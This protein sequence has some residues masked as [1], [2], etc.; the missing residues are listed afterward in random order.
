MP[1]SAKLPELGR[2]DEDDSVAPVGRLLEGSL[3]ASSPKRAS[4]SSSSSPSS[5]SSEGQA[6]LF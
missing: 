2:I 5:E 6:F 1:T 4:T 3:G